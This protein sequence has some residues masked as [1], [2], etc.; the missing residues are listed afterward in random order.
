MGINFLAQLE[1]YLNH[2]KIINDVEKLNEFLASRT[3]NEFLASRN[4]PHFWNQDKVIFS[5][6]CELLKKCDLTEDSNKYNELI[7]I[8][9]AS[10]GMNI[11]Q[12]TH[13]VYATNS[14]VL[15]RFEN[16]KSEKKGFP[17]FYEMYQ[18]IVMSVGVNIREKDETVENR[19]I[20]RNP[21]SIVNNDFRN[22]SM[23]LHEFTCQVICEFFSS[24]RCF[25]VRPMPKMAQILFESL[26]KDCFLINGANPEKSEFIGEPCFQIN[27][28][29][30]KIKK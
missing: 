14:P 7:S 11:K 8:T 23:L 20:F 2:I 18:D 25:Y 13:V 1:I 12:Q 27:V 15:T 17:K 10:S 5:E 16:R 29:A 9:H 24:V 4:F 3:M 6:F 26:E 28:Q 19:G 30:F 21:I 22:I